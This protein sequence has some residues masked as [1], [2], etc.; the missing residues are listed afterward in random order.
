VPVRPEVRLV[1]AG[2]N[3]AGNVAPAAALIVES[4]ASPARLIII[5]MVVRVVGSGGKR[6]TA[7][8]LCEV[9]L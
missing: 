7:D 3:R 9:R 8:C 5:A 1:D 4:R 6:M 2:A